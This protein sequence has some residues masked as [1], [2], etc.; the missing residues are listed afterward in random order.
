LYH[1]PTI[2]EVVTTTPPPPLGERDARLALDERRGGGGE[3]RVEVPR[4]V[5]PDGRA[6]LGTANQREVHARVRW[7]DR[8]RAARVSAV[9]KRPAR[10]T[11]LPEERAQRRGAR[12]VAAQTAVLDVVAGVRRAAHVVR[13]P[14]E[15]REPIEEPG[16]ARTRGPRRDGDVHDERVVQVHE[17][18]RLFLVRQ[19]VERNRLQ[20]LRRASVLAEG[21]RRT[22]ALVV[23][24][25]A[26][27]AEKLVVQTQD[28]LAQVRGHRAR[29]S[30]RAAE[31]PPRVE[32]GERLG[33]RKRRRR[34]RVVGEPEGNRTRAVFVA[35]D[36]LIQR[37]RAVRAREQAELAHARRDR[38]D[39]S[40]V[41]VF[42]VAFVA[43]V[44]EGASRS[45]VARD[46]TRDVG[47]GDHAA[48][49]FERATPTPERPAVTGK[50][51]AAHP[52][53]G[54][55][56]NRVRRVR[57]EAGTR[58][59]RDALRGVEG[60]VARRRRRRRR[61]GGGGECRRRRVLRVGRGALDSPG[62]LAGLDRGDRVVRTAH[63]RAADEHLGNRAHAGDGGCGVAND[64]VGVGRVDL[65][66]R[67]ARLPERRLRAAAVGTR[68]GLHHRHCGLRL[69]TIAACVADGAWDAMVRRASHALLRVTTISGRRRQPGAGGVA[70]A[71][72][73]GRGVRRFE[74]AR[75]RHHMPRNDRRGRHP[76][77]SVA[78]AWQVGR[79][80]TL[81]AGDVMMTSCRRCTFFQSDLR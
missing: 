6:R 21:V 42:R 79:L 16:D 14:V 72:R 74:D 8:V 19:R 68:R 57:A 29:V 56:Q 54:V 32:R 35:D 4:V 37:A 71:A 80:T 27:V 46:P 20:R 51:V 39:R 26:V 66:E 40:R 23:H 60:A 59:R 3:L 52:L 24:E 53:R 10:H 65:D 44:G 33:V 75:A 22:H 15:V 31:A 55:I 30:R 34:R 77:R 47:A 50:Q 58:S 62:E 2:F 69:A 70:N 64:A 81:Q 41:V 76:A 63:A 67:D 17:E 11:R 9:A 7:Y 25:R 5:Q 48:L 12:P 61:G 73:V 18:R 49:E 1:E 28:A 38:R 78:R 13:V 36:A 45:L 43:F